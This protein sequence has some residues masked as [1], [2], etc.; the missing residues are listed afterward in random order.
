MVVRITLPALQLPPVSIVPEFLG[1]IDIQSLG[2]CSVDSVTMK[3]RE[4]LEEPLTGG[5]PHQSM[6]QS[7]MVGNSSDLVPCVRGFSCPGVQGRLIPMLQNLRSPI[8]L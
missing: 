3:E 6:N 5:H 1:R 8:C 4:E 2:T 7:I